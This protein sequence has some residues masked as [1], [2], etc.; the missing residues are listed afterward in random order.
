MIDPNQPGAAGILQR[1]GRFLKDNTLAFA[2]P[3]VAE[4][5]AADATAFGLAFERVYQIVADPE[6]LD[7]YPG[8]YFA[9]PVVE[10]LDIASAVLAGVQVAK[11]LESEKLWIDD[12]VRSLLGSSIRTER[13]GARWHVIESSP[14]L[15]EPL[16][17]P[18]P[19]F[20]APNE[21]PA[22]TY[23]V[24]SDGRDCL[25]AAAAVFLQRNG[26]CRAMR[27]ATPEGDYAVRP[28][29]LVSPALLERMISARIR[30]LSPNRVPLIRIE[31]TP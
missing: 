22:G 6:H 15:P 1:W 29:Y 27:V 5:A 16:W 25:S 26:L 24:Q 31:E 30:G 8:Y 11:D 2:D 9:P 4:K 21:R 17:F 23:I 18:R 12:A 28:R 10:P 7:E 19:V 13:A 3:R 20:V 14:E